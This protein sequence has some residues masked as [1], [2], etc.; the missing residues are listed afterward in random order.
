M[1]AVPCKKLT[2]TGAHSEGLR[3]WGVGAP[4]IVIQEDMFGLKIQLTRVLGW[5]TE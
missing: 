5:A 4:D 3:C 1:G 2:T